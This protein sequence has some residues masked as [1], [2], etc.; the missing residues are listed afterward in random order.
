MSS[1]LSSAFVLLPALLLY[2]VYLWW[3]A[4]RLHRL[5]QRVELS[6][7]ALEIALER[8]R[9]AARDLA[10]ALGPEAGRELAAAVEETLAGA[11]GD[12]AESRLSRA[13]RRAAAGSAGSSTPRRR[14]LVAA[15]GDAARSLHMA[16]TF[17]NDAVADTRRARRSRTVRLLRLAGG[18]PLPDF[19]EIDDQPPRAPVAPARSEAS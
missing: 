19:Y 12:L 9:R 5:H 13:L 1:A 6:R 16:R 17:Y 8:R 18:A 3:R 11:D 2:G 10:E 15:A 4:T 7:T 14:A